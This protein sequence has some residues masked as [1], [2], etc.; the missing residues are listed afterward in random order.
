M[1]KRAT[2]KDVAKYAD[3][4]YQTVSRVINDKPDVAPETRRRVLEAIE[5]VNYRPSMAATSRAQP[6]TYIM[7]LAVSPYN[8]FLL[9]EGD[10]HL[11]RI[12]HGID[13]ALA[14][15]N[16]SLLLSTIHFNND[17]AIE[18]RLLARQLAD[19]VIIRLSLDDRGQTA[20]LFTKKGYPVVVIG[21]SHDPH[22]PSVRSDDEN[23][24]YT[25][26]QHLLALGHRNIGIISGPEADPATVMRKQGHRLAMVES[27]LDA[28]RTPSVEG[29]YTVDS[30][31]DAAA[32]LMQDRSEL[33][34]IVAFS[35]T[36]AI[37]AMQWLSEHGYAIPGDISIVGYDDIPDAQRQSPSLTTIRIP[38]INECE[39]AVQV[40]FDLI[41]N[42]KL[43]S[44]EIV[45]PV[46]LVSRN[47]T[48]VPRDT[49]RDP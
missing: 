13:R 16:Y 25:Q 15:R 40:L 30:G 44:N 42:R 43:Y 48:S 35:D 19:G 22:I 17:H 47:S 34:A 4:S 27:G 8:E 39:R 9:Y 32:Q 11:L 1:A 21:Y 46:H 5:A 28:D 24:A 29:N 7:A 2:I 36:M 18:S 38:S 45:L 26:T 37:G 10:P 23:G 49:M 3:T 31:Y 20:S 41:E 6:K 14:I 12:I 33:T